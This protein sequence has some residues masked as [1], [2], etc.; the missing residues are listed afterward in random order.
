MV[1]KLICSATGL[2]LIL[3]SSAVAANRDIGSLKSRAMNK[4][5]SAQR[6]SMDA[7][8]TGIAARNKEAEF[9]RHTEAA[10]HAAKNLELEHRKKHSDKAKR[11]LNDSITL[12]GKTAEMAEA[13]KNAHSDAKGHYQDVLSAREAE[14][15]RPYNRFEKMKSNSHSMMSS[16][17]KARARMDE[18]ATD[19]AKSEDRLKKLQDKI[20]KADTI[21]R[22]SDFLPR[23]RLVEAQ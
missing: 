23:D 21:M 2:V 6:L 5:T 4:S 12:H 14:K 16:H 20:K 22:T 13:S 17:D 19:A 10:S 18:L 1:K 15:G 8:K 7:E 3:A 9:Q 11:A